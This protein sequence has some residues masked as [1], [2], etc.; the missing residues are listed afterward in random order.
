MATGSADG[1][2]GRDGDKSLAAGE[3]LSV[4]LA[5]AN[6]NSPYSEAERE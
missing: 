4:A 1:N 6:A 5:C 2:A 3:D